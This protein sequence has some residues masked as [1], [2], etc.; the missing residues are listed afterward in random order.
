MCFIENNTST[1][2]NKVKCSLYIL[3]SFEMNKEWFKMN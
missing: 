2:E 1:L 3:F